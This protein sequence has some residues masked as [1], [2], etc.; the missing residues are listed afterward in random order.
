MLQLNDHQSLDS[1]WISGSVCVITHEAHN[2]DK[3]TKGGGGGESK[4]SKI[5]AILIKTVYV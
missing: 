4:I 5:I 2:F 3:A 1:R